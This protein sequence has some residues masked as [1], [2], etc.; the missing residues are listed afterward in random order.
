MVVEDVIGDAIGGMKK[1]ASKVKNIAS[2]I[3]E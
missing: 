2:S 3:L 1:V